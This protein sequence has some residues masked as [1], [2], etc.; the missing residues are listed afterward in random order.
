MLGAL[1]KHSLSTQAQILSAMVA[2]ASSNMKVGTSL[3]VWQT[4]SSS[5]GLRRLSSLCTIFVA[6]VLKISAAMRMQA[7]K[8]VPATSKRCPALA[9]IAGPLSCITEMQIP[10]AAAHTRVHEHRHHRARAL[11]RHKAHSLVQGG[12]H[13][14]RQERHPVL[15]RPRSDQCQEHRCH[16]P[17][18]G[19]QLCMLCVLHLLLAGFLA[20][21]SINLL[22]FPQ[23]DCRLIVRSCLAPHVNSMTDVS[24]LFDHVTTLDLRCHI[25]WHVLEQPILCFCPT[26]PATRLHLTPPCPHAASLR[27]AG[28]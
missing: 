14:L 18:T 13:H 12:S 22:S 9:F 25:M 2:S 7:C 23:D 28:G 20:S 1:G 4:P 21:A 15:G 8:V 27:S 24:S 6:A 17:C 26:S 19:P 3:C 11:G 10:A 16:P 5:P